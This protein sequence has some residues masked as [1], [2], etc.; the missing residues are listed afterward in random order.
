MGDVAPSTNRRRARLEEDIQDQ[1]IET[2]EA[3]EGE[4]EEKEPS[5]EPEGFSLGSHDTLEE[6]TPSL[7]SHMQDTFDVEDELL[8]QHYEDVDLCHTPCW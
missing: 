1:T 8:S 6:A 5:Q 7:H 3:E 4:E 2:E